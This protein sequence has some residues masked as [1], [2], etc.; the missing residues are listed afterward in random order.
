MADAITFH[1]IYCDLVMLAKSNSLNKNVL[2]MNMHCMELQT[3][4]SEVEHY[5][6]AAVD[7]S[8]QVFPSE[9]WL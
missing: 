4:I 2:D 7:C 1:H 6:E 5:P 9:E 8:G 3:F